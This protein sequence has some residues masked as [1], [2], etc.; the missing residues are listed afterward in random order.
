[1]VLPALTLSQS[2][3]QSLTLDM[4]GQQ[5]QLPVTQMNGRN[6]VEVEALARAANGSVSFQGNAMRLTLGGGRNG[7]SNNAATNGGSSNDASAQQS[8]AANPGFSKEFVRSGIELMA[9]IREWRSV[10]SN[11]VAN[12]YPIASLGLGNYQA[13]AQQ[14]L[15]MASTVVTTDSD[16]SAYQ[17]LANE[18][19]NMKKMSDKYIA[20]AQNMNYIDPDSVKNDSLDQSIINCAHS[21][22]AMA[23]SGQ[24]NDDGSCH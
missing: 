2:A 23:S 11:G 15:R 17:L 10:L 12:G 3:P 5:A 7:T 20:K 13:Q 1:M 24:F 16:R 9:A 6:Y 22:A 19:A 21:L 8:P 4:N 18:Y 14:S